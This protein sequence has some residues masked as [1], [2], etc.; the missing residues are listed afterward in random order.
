MQIAFW[1]TVIFN[2]N[3]NLKKENHKKQNIQ[4]NLKQILSNEKNNKNISI[5]HELNTSSTQIKFL[6]NPLT[7]F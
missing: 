7:E 4:E 1:F 2:K 5:L 3:V 6:K